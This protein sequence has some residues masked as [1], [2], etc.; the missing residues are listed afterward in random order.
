MLVKM[1]TVFLSSCGAYTMRIRFVFTVIV[2][3]LV[4]RTSSQEKD[5]QNCENEEH[6]EDDERNGNDHSSGHFV[7]DLQRQ[8]SMC[9]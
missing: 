1:F 5:E 3:L 2:T 7:V 4:G 6:K 9:H 8:R